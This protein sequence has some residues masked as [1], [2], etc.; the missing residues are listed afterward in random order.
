MTKPISQTGRAE[1][2]ALIRELRLIIDEKNG[3]IRR[4]QRRIKNLEARASKARDAL[5]GKE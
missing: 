1:L 5:D 3:E 4:W 2:E